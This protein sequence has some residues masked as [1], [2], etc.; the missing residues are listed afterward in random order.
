MVV[1]SIVVG[2]DVVASDV[3]V[4]SPLSDPSLGVSPPQAVK[5]TQLLKTIVANLIGRIVNSIS[6][7]T[8][9]HESNKTCP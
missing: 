1:G 6:N 7:G 3:E 4:S 2:S 5:T 8:K 9:V